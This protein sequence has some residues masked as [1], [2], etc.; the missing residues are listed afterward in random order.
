MGSAPVLIA[1]GGLTG[2]SAALHLRRPWL[3]LERDRS[4]GGLS[5]TEE[6]DGFFFD[7]TGHWLHLRDP[8]ILAL[9]ERSAE[10]QMVQVQRRAK[11]YAAGR[12]IHY[13]FQANVHELPPEVAYE[14]LLGY[15]R[16][17]MERRAEEPRNFEQYILHHFGAGI[18]RHFMVPYNSK[19]W[20]VHPREITSAWCQRFVPVP[21]VE[22]MIAGAI[23]SSQGELGYNVRFH[24]PRH[25]GIETLTRALIAPLD[26][27]RVRLGAEV[28]QID[29]RQRTVRA[30]GETLRYE[31][32]ITSLP[33]PELIG[34]LV[35]PP[36]EVVAAARLLR[37]M[38][39]RY[40]NV[41]TRSRPPED[42]HWTYVPEERLPFYRVGVFSNAVPSMAPPGCAS[43]YVELAGR[44]PIVDRG[45]TVA[46]AV[47]ALVE[48]RAIPSAEDVVFADLREIGYAY[49]VFDEHYEEA[50]A[51][52]FPYLE[53][54]R[55]FSCG[56][57]GSWI[58]NS[59]EDS[60][61]AG[62]EAAMRVDGL[63]AGGET[64]AP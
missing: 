49:V 53:Q 10:G 47:R 44:E 63:P 8:E 1:G 37:C 41:A 35:D 59:M 51:A 14:C 17:L 42:Y 50:L 32:L 60:L 30:A 43:L 38:S 4:L 48:V 13:P 22:Q 26:P 6:R 31:A 23:G 45:R 58:Y 16:S 2:I 36:A 33:L 40:L 7:R 61:A 54:Q 34:R 28:E 5:R 9:I 21:T 56:R 25:G 52:I 62:R 29:P 11:V 57:Y 15:V 24:Y 55:I 12:L 3:L 27:G 19:L 39:V 46:E 20:G 18:A 64:S